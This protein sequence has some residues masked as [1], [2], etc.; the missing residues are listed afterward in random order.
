MATFQPTL[1]GTNISHNYIN[2]GDAL[3]VTL[4]MYN[5]GTENAA[6]RYRFTMDLTYGHQ[7]KL[8]NKQYNYRVMAD[9]FPSTDQWEP[10]METAVTLRWEVHSAWAG[11]FHLTV[12]M[13]DEEGLPV[14]FTVPGYGTVTSFE[15][16]AINA[17][18]NFGRP[19]VLENTR[20]I[21]KE[22]PFG[23]TA[24]IKKQMPAHPITLA[25]EITVK[26]AK[27]IPHILEING[28][29]LRYAVPVV[30]VKHMGDN[31]RFIVN[32]G[33]LSFNL[34]RQTEKEA[35][36]KTTVIIDG[37]S[38]A[39]FY[40]RLALKGRVLSV[41]LCE[42]EEKPG[43]ELLSVQYPTL[44]EIKGGCL[45]DF[46]GGGRL[47]PIKEATP[48]FFD[49]PYDVRN[50]AALYDDNN[51]FIVESEH[52]D[53]WMS[54]G[55]YGVNGEKRGFIGGTI[56]CRIP[57][58]GNRPG[59]P[60]TKPPVFT[61]EC[62][63][64]EGHA[65]DWKTAAR[66]FRRG[67]KPNYARDLYRD[68][69]FY[70]QLSTW[71]PE[72]AAHYR[73]SD[74]HVLTQNLYRSV[75]FAKIAENVRGFANM[76]DRTKQVMYVTGFQIGGFDNA[77]PHPFDTDV[78][79]GSLADLA[80]CLEDMREHNA[81]SGL[82]DN[83]DDVSA[84]HVNDYPHVALD[85]RGE[86]WHGWVW[87]AGPTY[88][89]G[90]KS[91]AQS[92]ALAERVKKMTEILPLRDSYHLDVLTAET[93]RYDFN[94][95]CPSS[96][97]DS[98]DAKME[99]IAEWNKYGIDI[100]SEML[101]HP[102]TGHIGFALHTR[103]D[104]REVFIPGDR[105]VPLTHMV[106]HGII[107]Y[108]APSRSNRDILWGLLVGGQTFYEDDITGPL[109]ISRFYIQNIPAMKLYDKIMTDFNQ[110]GKTARADYGQ[111]SY[112]A[113]NFA[114]ETYEVVVDGVLIAQ[115]FTTLVPGNTPGVYLA[116][117]FD[118]KSVTYPKPKNGGAEIRAVTLTPE[119]EGE[120]LN[121]A[122]RVEGE[123]VILQLPPLTPVKL[124]FE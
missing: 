74:P 8:D 27:D 78:R 90:F 26:L 47:I 96:A 58:E 86:P 98:H 114:D 69:Y 6:G 94:P 124:L 99:V 93:C 102:S 18:W 44:A 105:F 39:V 13:L 92:G 19:W 91:F 34:T 64:T 24:V 29:P 83:F 88:M 4:F 119:G 43:Y 11:T 16:G 30:K 100:T 111:G 116:Y 117:A 107:G 15:I 54:T 32:G 1:I 21:T 45:L 80:K 106:Y 87:P 57:A 7:R 56:V 71:G 120:W 104:T 36:Y 59:I 77:Y 35:V 75:T 22:Y 55:V 81:L 40:L 112:V 61:V 109:C 73:T 66:L 115:N 72:P 103:M 67:V 63:D 60:V 65:P 121:N 76:T 51:L 79:C 48:L 108:S 52:L 118:N 68:T 50:A 84:L 5:N 123:T 53:S 42:R 28:V 46:Y 31:K 97:Q 10:G 70:K 17:S 20:P 3:F 49:R 89:V 85:A 25:D 23:K 122:A 82:H 95:A 113:V 62:C 2:P 12:G 33:E 37:I 110:N 9:P 38:A 41:G 101:N 14:P